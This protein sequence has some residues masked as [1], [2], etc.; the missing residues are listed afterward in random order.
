MRRRS[1][2]GMAAVLPVALSQV[3][4]AA[5]A[6][7]PIVAGVETFRLRVNRRGNWILVRLGTH[8]GLT[9]LGEASHGAHDEETLAAVQKYAALLRGRSILD[10]G[11]FLEAASGLAGTSATTSD[12][13]AISALEQC[14]WD[15]AGKSLGVPVHVLFG[16]KIR[17]SVRLYA[18]INRSSDPRTPEGFAAMAS[19][20]VNAGFHAIKLAPFDAIPEAGTDA[21]TRRQLTDAGVACAQAV[22][23]AIGPKRD[24]LIDA[25]SRFGVDEG[26]ALAHRLEPLDL[27]WLEEVTPAEPITQLAA[28]NDA[29]KMPTAGGESI[30]GAENFY[31]YIRAGAVDIV[32]PDI[33]LCGGMTELKKISGLAQGAGLPVSPHGPASPIGT[34]A[35]AHVM[36]T[37][38]NFNTLEFS[39]GEV[40]WR[41][42][43]ITPPE[44][45]GT[46]ALAV[47]S[48]PGLGIEL[49]D[50]TLLQHAI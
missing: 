44:S 40:P 2:L 5:T 29:A 32:M 19:A 22:R 27:F 39:F 38:P 8:S 1:L 30:Y 28:I 49:N 46:G 9:G 45:V 25:H 23:R 10:V 15:L 4:S 18:N 35:A 14:L 26:I 12:H 7:T 43:L 42:E 33:K 21:E 50:R 3:A 48:A 47:S 16:G 37:V 36:A 11:W 20:A 17:E 34:I 24:L 13:V 6:S 31:R 41:A